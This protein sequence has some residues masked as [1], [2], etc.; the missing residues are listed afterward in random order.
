M[1]D[2]WELFWTGV[3]LAQTAASLA[4]TV[5]VLLRRRA[6]TATAAWIGLAW[7]APATGAVL[8]L[9]LGVNRIERRARRLRRRHIDAPEQSAVSAIR[10]RHLMPLERA[11][12]VITGRVLLAEN[13]AVPLAHGEAA[14]PAM[15]EAIGAALHSIALSSYIFRDD[16]SGRRF[17][18][19]LVA[20]QGRGVAVRVLV[21]GVGGGYF[22]A[23]AFRRLRRQGVAV[24]R[25]LHSHLPWRM[26]VLNLRLHK[27]LLVVDGQVG[28]TGG[29]NIGDEN[30][31]TP[32]RRRRST[33]QRRR[34]VRDLHFRIDGP[35]VGQM[36]AAFAEDWHLAT[37]E[38]LRGEE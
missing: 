3:A 23:G 5:H 9:V 33:G 22:R 38:A 29:L 31:E 7:F 17:I 28:F 13:G 26:P 21:D 35:V 19:A 8:Y 37:G 18:E 27:K 34:G 16:H 10:P 36:M 1:G 2:Q 32:R 15:L 20:A 24:A 30:L 11:A 4:V 12:S 25:F 6:P 14:Y